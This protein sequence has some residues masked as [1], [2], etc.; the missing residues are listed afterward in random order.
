MNKEGT[1]S[2]NCENAT[3]GQLAGKGLPVRNSEG[4]GYVDQW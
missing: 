1:L 2:T 3:L 4:C